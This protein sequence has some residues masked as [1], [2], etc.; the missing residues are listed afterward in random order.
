MDTA[1]KRERKVRAITII[2]RVYLLNTY[3][4]QNVTGTEKKAPSENPAKSGGKSE[5]PL[6]AEVKAFPTRFSPGAEAN[7]HIN[8]LIRHLSGSKSS[9]QLVKVVQD[10]LGEIDSVLHEMRAVSE[11][12]AEDNLPQEER[13]FLQKRIDSYIAEIDQI[14]ASTELK[15]AMINS[16]NYSPI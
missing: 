3:R 2:S 8:G 4:K 15:A 14:A 12:A 9:V 16:K 5:K 7:N 1:R 6:K 11:R 13:L 10:A